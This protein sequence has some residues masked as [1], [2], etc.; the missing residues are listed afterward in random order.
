MAKSLGK[1]KRFNLQEYWGDEFDKF[2]LWLVQEEILEMIGEAIDVQ[3]VPVNHDLSAIRLKGGVVAKNV[4]NDDIVLIQGQLD[5]ITYSD[6]GQLIEAASS[7]DASVIVWV[8]TKIPDEH[9]RGLDWLNGVSGENVSFY[10]AELELWRIDDSAPAPNFSLVC[11]PNPWG[12]SV[13]PSQDAMKSSGLSVSEAPLSRQD[14]PP[15][16]KGDWTKKPSEKLN[17]TQQG[18][19]STQMKEDVAVRENFVY[20]KSL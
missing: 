13:K 1:L 18:E 3:L 10:A 17:P 2:S 5:G 16:R 8:A 6:F 12:E 19:S 11:Q 14:D 15:Q 4:K 20:T 7:V 9:K